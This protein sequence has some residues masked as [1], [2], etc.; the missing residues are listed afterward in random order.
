MPAHGWP[1]FFKSLECLLEQAGKFLCSC[2]HSCLV[3]LSYCHGQAVLCARVCV[4][5]ASCHLTADWPRVGTWSLRT[6]IE[7][8]CGVIPKFIYCLRPEKLEMSSRS[9]VSGY[10]DFIKVPIGSDQVF[11]SVQGPDISSLLF[12][13]QIFI[14]HLQ[15]ARH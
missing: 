10:K 11:M 14:K 15:R 8:S 5:F 9:L 1:F 3:F 7:I 12:I 6:L 2:E 13:Q 4:A